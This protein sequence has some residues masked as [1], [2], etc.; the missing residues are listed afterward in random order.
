M[1]DIHAPSVAAVP[2]IIHRLKAKGYRFVTVSQLLNDQAL[3][4]LQYFGRG[5]YRTAG[6]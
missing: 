1:H 5:D 6:K 3:P 4:G 2:T